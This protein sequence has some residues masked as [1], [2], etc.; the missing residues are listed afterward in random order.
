MASFCHGIDGCGC[1]ISEDNMVCAYYRKNGTKVPKSICKRC[2]KRQKA[3][4]DA[5]EINH[6]RPPSGTECEICGRVSKLNLDH[7][8]ATDKFRWFLCQNCNLACGL[9]GDNSKNVKNAFE[10]MERFEAN[11][12]CQSRNS[13]TSLKQ[14]GPDR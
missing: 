1:L 12:K 11:S 4:R 13:L 6:P 5:L 2:T 14:P 3:V 9:L 8:H 7:C 10:Y